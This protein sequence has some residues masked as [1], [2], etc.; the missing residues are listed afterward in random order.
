MITI[1]DFSRIEQAGGIILLGRV[2][3]KLAVA[4][5][6]GDLDFKNE[7]TLEAKW[8]TAEPD[9]L[10]RCKFYQ[11]TINRLST[12]FF[13]NYSSLTQIRTYFRS[14]AYKRNRIYIPRM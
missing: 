11:T 6:F 4:R 9:I 7:Q 2:Q 3:G 1:Y 13:K 10:F 14:A 5:S 12:F 8:I